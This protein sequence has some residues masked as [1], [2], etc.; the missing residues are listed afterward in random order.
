MPCGSSSRRRPRRPNGRG[1][2]GCRRSTRSGDVPRE[3]LAEKQVL[4]PVIAA[5]HDLRLVSDAPSD[6]VSRGQA[7]FERLR[8][9]SQPP[10]ETPPETPVPEPDDDATE[11]LGAPAQTES[12]IAADVAEPVAPVVGDSAPAPAPAPLDHPPK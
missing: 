6:L 11:A 9:G 10:V 3:T 5:H 12:D 7:I 2:S 4:D 1:R 8:T